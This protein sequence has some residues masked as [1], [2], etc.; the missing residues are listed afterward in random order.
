[1][2]N[3]TVSALFTEQ[4]RPQTLD[5]VL[6]VDRVRKQLQNELNSEHGIISNLL[7]YGTQGAGKT[8][9]SRIICKGHDKFRYG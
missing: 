8:T 5:Q 2:A 4:L 6:L 3:N 7:F 9:L 1:M